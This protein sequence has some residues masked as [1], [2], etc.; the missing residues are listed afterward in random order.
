[1]AAIFHDID[2]FIDQNTYGPVAALVSDV[3]TDRYCIIQPFNYYA[4]YRDKTIYV[5]LPT[6]FS[7]TSFVCNDSFVTGKFTAN[8]LQ[9]VCSNASFHTVYDIFGRN[10][11]TKVILSREMKSFSLTDILNMCIEHGIFLL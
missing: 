1:M 11:F 6:S 8:N 4:V 9:I 3:D 10:D 5:V 7:G 2:R